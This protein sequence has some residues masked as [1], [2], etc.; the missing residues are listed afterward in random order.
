M[1]SDDVAIMLC[2]TLNRGD[3]LG[4]RVKEFAVE[5]GLGEEMSTKMLEVRPGRYCSSPRPTH[6]KPSPLS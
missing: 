3:V 4:D 1:V 2:K 5:F 6:F